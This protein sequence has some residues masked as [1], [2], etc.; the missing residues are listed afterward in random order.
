MVLSGY[1]DTGND[2]MRKLLLG[3]IITAISATAV[4]GGLDGVWQTAA[5]DNGAYLHVTLGPC[6]SDS[7]K[8]CG[9]ITEA[10]TTQGPD[11]KYANLGKPIVTHMS[12][13]DGK[14]YSG[15]TVWDPEKNKTYKSKLHL[16]G[17]VLDVE[18]CISFICIG[19]DWTR[20]N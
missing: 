7:S 13:H 2:I 6:D 12:S 17:D 9:T 20:V 8:T 15:G 18:G 10:F 19:Q 11:P 4:A 1:V 16:K 3:L 5:D 14:K